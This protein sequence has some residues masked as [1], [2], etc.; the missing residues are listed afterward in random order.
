MPDRTCGAEA[1]RA[2]RGVAAGNRALLR[3]PR[4]VR[5]LAEQRGRGARWWPRKGHL[6]TAPPGPPA[7]RRGPESDTAPP[8]RLLPAGI[9]QFRQVAV[10]NRLDQV[11]VE[12][13]FT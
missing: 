8:A 10:V 4:L 11:I 9:E 5:G 2:G 6:E 3:D 13:G 1:G 12:P 7:T